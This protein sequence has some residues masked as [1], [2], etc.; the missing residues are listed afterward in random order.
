MLS[1]R[2]ISKRG[3][4]LFSRQQFLPYID[5]QKT[6]HHSRV[7]ITRFHSTGRCLWEIARRRI[8]KGTAAD[9][10][11]ITYWFQAKNASIRRHPYEV[12][13]TIGSSRRLWGAFTQR[14]TARPNVGFGQKATLQ[15]NRRTCRNEPAVSQGVA[16]SDKMFRRTMSRM[17]APNALHLAGDYRPA[18]RKA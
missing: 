16:R 7:T 8:Q 5:R 4:S 6:R 14:R 18:Q 11:F 10:T 12:W 17:E 15:R 3:R 13:K 9:R 2:R 1:F